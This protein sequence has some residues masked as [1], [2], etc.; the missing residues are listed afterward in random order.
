MGLRPITSHPSSCS[1]RNHT[2]SGPLGP[3]VQSHLIVFQKGMEKSE[4]IHSTHNRGG[5]TNN[6]N[7]LS[8]WLKQCKRGS[9]YTCPC[10]RAHALLP[11]THAHTHTPPNS[12]A[13][14]IPLT[15][16]PLAGL[17]GWW[18]RE[19]PAAIP[20]ASPPKPPSL[21]DKTRLHLGL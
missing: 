2:A 19:R 4:V 15:H 8:F 9:S 14:S 5:L 17:Q 21:S 16:A 13:P 1:P 10:I 20:G 3:H 7:I 6:R 12:C 18:T 11:D